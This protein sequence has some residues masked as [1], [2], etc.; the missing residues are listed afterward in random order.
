[1]LCNFDVKYEIVTDNID[2][3]DLSMLFREMKTLQTVVGNV[4]KKIDKERG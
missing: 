4:E 3:D 2:N 1:M